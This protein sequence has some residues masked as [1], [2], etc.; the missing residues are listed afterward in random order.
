MT[1][2]HWTPDLNTGIEEI[3]RQHR[4]I[5]YYINE[6][7]TQIKKPD[8]AMLA[9]V[10]A[11]VVDYTESHFAFEE[12]MLKQ[13]GYEF[14]EL[15]MKVHRLFINRINNIKQRFEDGQNVAEEL[16]QVLSR[17][18]FGHIRT[19]DHGYCHDVKIYLQSQAS[20]IELGELETLL[21]E[22]DEPEEKKG[23]LQRLM[24]R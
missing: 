24:G 22:L 1:I 11:A 20:A 17:W 14:T 15:H 16:H 13:A 5:V 10:V 9:K 8:Q 18:L 4:R 21:P 12:A 7:N 23:W 6:L 2:L 19:E 3:D